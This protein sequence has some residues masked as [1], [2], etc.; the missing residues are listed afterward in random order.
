MRTFNNVKAFIIPFVIL[1][2]TITIAQ[3]S[4]NNAFL[5]DGETSQLSVKDDDPGDETGF[6]FFNSYN[7]ITVQAWIYLLGD[8]P[9]GVEVPVVYRE[10]QTGTTFGTTF[11]MYVKNNRGYFTVGESAPVV[12]P[13]FPAFRWTA[14]TGTYDGSDLKIYLDGDLVEPYSYYDITTST[15]YSTNSESGLFVGNSIGLTF[16]FFFFACFR[17]PF[18]RPFFEVIAGPFHINEG[19]LLSCS[20]TF[21]VFWIVKFCIRSIFRNHPPSQI[22][23]IKDPGLYRIIHQAFFEPV[24]YG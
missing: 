10:V 20:R 12:T 11:S 9:A 23:V 6:D 18:F 1:L 3:Q 4:N 19:D 2:T 22:A 14:L 24:C 16:S 21:Y 15:S 13:E 7:H 17:F 8:S 5:L